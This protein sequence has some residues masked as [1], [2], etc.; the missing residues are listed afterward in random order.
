M[1]GTCRERDATAA[2]LLDRA[3]AFDFDTVDAAICDEH[4]PRVD[5]GPDRK[6]QAVT[7]GRQVSDRGRDADAVAAVARPWADA[8]GMWIV[9]IPDFRVSRSARGLKE[10]AIQ[11]LP[12]LGARPLDPD[13]PSDPMKIAAD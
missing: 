13:R 2:H 11:G 7:R 1:Y 8:G 3:G 4:A 10:G 12:G 9:V 5:A 6:I